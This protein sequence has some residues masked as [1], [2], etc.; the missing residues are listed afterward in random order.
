MFF[1][2]K[3]PVKCTLHSTPPTNLN[4]LVPFYCCEIPCRGLPDDPPRSSR[5]S[6]RAGWCCLRLAASLDA[7]AIN[8]AEYSGQARRDKIDAA[9]I[10]VQVLLDRAR[11]SPGEI[12][13][14]LGENAEKAL[15]AFAEA[16]GM[17]PNKLLTPE[18]WKALA[19]TGS[20]AAI[21]EYKI[22]E[23]GLKGPF[24]KKLRRKWRT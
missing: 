22:S 14:K 17:P 9:V 23:R 4:L 20:D 21:T 7:A 24:L 6:F 11:F 12:D 5:P 1:R 3:H 8:G 2:G 13:G 15:K 18:I 10:K 16:K 19:G